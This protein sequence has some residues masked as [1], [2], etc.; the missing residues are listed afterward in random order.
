[1]AIDSNN[2][3]PPRH[4]FWLFIIHML[5]ALGPEKGRHQELRLPWLRRQAHQGKE[6]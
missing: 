4:I 5:R 6:H 1:M 2:T 3:D